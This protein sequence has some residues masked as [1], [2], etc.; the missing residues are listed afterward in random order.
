MSGLQEK[1]QEMNEQVH[2]SRVAQTKLSIYEK[3]IEE[4]SLLQAKVRKQEQELEDLRDQGQLIQSMQHK[5]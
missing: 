3:K 1:I 2:D 4:I 5:M